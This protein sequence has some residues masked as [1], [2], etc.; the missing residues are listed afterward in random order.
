MAFQKGHPGYRKKK[1][2]VRPEV[3]IVEVI[4]ESVIKVQD[5]VELHAKLRKEFPLFFIQMNG[6]QD[7][8]IRVKN[9]N[10]ETP[11]R[12][13]F[14]AAN[15]IGKTRVGLMEDMAYAF[16]F[17]P[18]LKKDDPDYFV[19]VKIPSLGMLGCETYK[20]SVAEKIEPELRYLVPSTCQAVF[21][22]G[23]TGVLNIVK[24]PFDA[25]GGKCGSELHIR[26]Y[27]E[28]P[29]SFEGQDYNYIHWDEP[30]PEDIWKAA[31]RGKIVTNAPSW[32]TMTALKE[33]WIY[34]LLTIKAAVFSVR[35]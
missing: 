32:F 27:D 8:F 26:S 20:H 21:K 28:Q 24:F 4:A 22:P 12:R 5:K 31:E 13:L 10:R 17:R 14:E 9:V 18:W 23:P 7:R 19:D 1:S 16:G 33:P 30:P 34:D 2:E 25:K 11:R 6:A 3:P 35:N 15:K 29:S